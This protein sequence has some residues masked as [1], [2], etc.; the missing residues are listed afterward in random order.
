MSS[1]KLYL[2]ATESVCLDGYCQ[3][4]VVVC[5]PG[6]HVKLPDGNF[7]TGGCQVALWWLLL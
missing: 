3:S 1:S 7:I 6:S 4:Q 2:D 5:L